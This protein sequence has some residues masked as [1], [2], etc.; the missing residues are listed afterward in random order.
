MSKSIVLFSLSLA[1]AGCG[2]SVSGHGPYPFGRGDDGGEVGD[3]G[4]GG[5]TDGSGS[6]GDGGSGDSDGGNDIALSIGGDG[7]QKTGGDDGSIL[8]CGTTLD[9]QGCGCNT[10]G[11]NR[12]CYTGPAGTENK[13]TCRD[14]M[15]T[16]QM[17]GEFSVWGPCGG[18][19]KP[20]PENCGDDLDHNCNGLIGCDD[21]MCAGMGGCC[22]PGQMRK[23][24]DGPNG[25]EG[26]GACHDGMQTC[27]L[28]GAWGSCQGETL[29]QAEVGHCQDMIDNN[30]NGL[31]D[32]LDPACA[33][34]PFC[35]PQVCTPNAM[36][37]CY[38][39]PQGTEGVGPCHGGTQTCAPD[40]SAWGP[41]QN[42][43]LPGVEAGHCADMIDN[44]CNGLVDCQ[45]PAC[46]MDPNCQHVLPANAWPRY[47]HDNRNSGSTPTVVADNPKLKWK[48]PV[49]GCTLNH[50]GM[51]SGPVVN[52]NNVLFVTAG[53]TNLQV[54]GL[55]SYT[56]A[57]N[58]L[59][60]LA[61]GTGFAS[62]TPAVRN[63]G[64]V[65]FSI[66]QGG[67]LFAVDSMGKSSWQFPTGSQADSD[68]V[69]TKGGIV[70]YSSDDGS[71]YA[72]DFQGNLQWKSDP[73]TGPGEVDVGLAESDD[74][75]VYAGGRNGWYALNAV[76]GQTIWHVPT[77]GGTASLLSSP[78]V[79]VDGKMYGFDSGGI[80]YAIDPNGNVLWKKPIGPSAFG[81]AST[82][83]VG[84]T[85]I[86]VLNDGKLY[87]V[88][89]GT[90][91]VQWSQ[92]VGA[93][94][95][96]INAG[97]ISDGKG[98]IYV[99]GNDG[100]LYSFN[101][102]GQLLWKLPTSGVNNPFMDVVGT[103]AIGNDGTL[104]VPG[105][106]GNLYAFQ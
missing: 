53:D 10:P 74:G 22:V 36:K 66:Q 102:A 37:A 11:A 94:A 34:D 78:L 27:D 67:M 97:P 31:T 51:G 95:R 72:L 71:L 13:G 24:Y 18:D 38:D 103:P 7:G 19:I 52:Q 29:P 81:G 63:D 93:A 106:D 55:H 75:R 101:V 8:G 5:A 65:Y 77:T 48:I 46:A 20:A 105:N 26:I 9:Q 28:H 17:N 96:E 64:T 82:G 45:D 91:A 88:D 32:C 40:G 87:G 25:T 79:D 99:N 14:G 50:G 98:H 61:A 83:K 76:N 1:V 6:V 44:D 23:C 54:Q 56:A 21:P 80:G 85:L 47:R 30:C 86:S 15:Q 89:A 70:I 59:Y 2:T 62:S 73:N 4:D 104:Y 49:G 35:K 92:P 41:C 39:G 43:A 57:G 60:F 69:V 33:L 16:C 3:G 90:G 42:E 58:S 68:P 12:A 100:F 84:N